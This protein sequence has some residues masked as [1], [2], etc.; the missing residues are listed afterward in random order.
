MLKNY[1]M[2]SMRVS[3]LCAVLSYLR[4]VFPLNS[5]QNVFFYSLY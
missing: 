4:S 5:Q 2:L 1:W 3:C